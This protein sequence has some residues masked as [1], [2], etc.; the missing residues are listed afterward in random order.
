MHRSRHLTLTSTLSGRVS[1][2]GDRC[3]GNSL[4]ERRRLERRR[5]G[6]AQQLLVPETTDACEGLQTSSAP[7]F[8]RPPWKPTAN[9]S[10][11][12]IAV[13][14]FTERKQ[15][16]LLVSASIPADRHS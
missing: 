16:A 15:L 11:A 3:P 2:R 4:G 8:I 10:N 5:H 12:R 1:A 13:E 14:P 6:G 9:P 7:G